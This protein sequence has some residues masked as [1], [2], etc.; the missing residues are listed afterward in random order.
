MMY[1][2]QEFAESPD[3]LY[4]DIATVDSVAGPWQTLAGFA[5]PSGVTGW[6]REVV[7]LLPVVSSPRVF[8]SFRGISKYGNNIFLDDVTVADT[9][10][11][12]LRLLAFIMTSDSLVASPNEAGNSARGQSSG[13]R[14]SNGFRSADPHSVV[15]TT[16]SPVINVVVG[17]VGTI[18]EAAYQVRWQVDGQT[19]ITASNLRAVN[20]GAMDTIRLPRISPAAGRHLVTAW[21]SLPADSN[22]TN[23][24]LMVF[25]EIIDT[26]TFFAQMFNA[27]PFPPSGWS[28][29]NRDGGTLPPWFQGTSASIFPPYEGTGFAADNFQRAN[30]SYID[31]YL[32]TPPIPGV[33]MTNYVDTLS[34]YVRSP[35]YAPPA[36]NY[37][38]S[39]MILLS[40]SGAD[41]S[42][43][44]T[45][46]D[47]F[48]VPKTG[49]TKKT[50]SLGGRVPAGS[51][52]RFA[53]RY[54]HFNGGASGNNSDFVGLDFVQLIRRTGTGV[55]E[56]GSQATT[57]LLLQNYPNPFNPNTSIGY[58]IGYPARVALKVFSILG[59]EV[60]TLVDGQQVAGTRSV[61]WNGESSTGAP[62]AS[63]VYFYTLVARSL[64]GRNVFSSTRK[65]MFIK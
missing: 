57:F 62:V 42:D 4:I 44:T 51:T 8:I 19:Q 3:S 39:L 6:K 32:I 52:V 37:N 64:D 58:S 15:A 36:Q 10:F 17:N 63:G 7:S 20:P 53:F 1:H 33:G 48:L 5:R 55:Q 22:R 54:L 2:D 46:L 25:I 26:S 9:S 47:Y 28:V 38:D 24:T 30:G 13:K 49:W 29:I 61:V 41:T 40:T 56:P 27:V 16:S 59:Q 43:F 21:I 23:D 60:A 65:M 14:I 18:S 12:D 50:Y 34:F 31:D 45:T 11:H 35:Y